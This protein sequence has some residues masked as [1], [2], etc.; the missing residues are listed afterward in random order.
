MPNS[1][2]KTFGERLIDALEYQGIMDP[3]QQVEMVA[4]A[5]QIT[6][7]TAR[8]YLQASSYPEFLNHNP[9]RLWSLAGK[10]EV[11]PVW[12]LTGDGLTPEEWRVIKSVRLMS[13]WE[14]TKFI[15]YGIRLLNDDAKARRLGA[16][17][18]A[19]QISRH[20]LFASM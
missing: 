9:M 16:M 8:K 13:K 4:Q 12:L 15:R 17:F 1:T 7:R 2:S 3:V 5:C 10:L 6:S 19:G 20:T 11:N 14:K 18:D